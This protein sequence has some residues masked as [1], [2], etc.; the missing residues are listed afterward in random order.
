MVYDEQEEP[1]RFPRRVTAAPPVAVPASPAVAASA[2]RAEGRRRGQA[3]A[4][5]LAEMLLLT[6][7]IFLTVRALVVNFRVDGNSMQPTLD[8]GA[9]LLVN[10]AVYFHLDLN[11]LRNLLPGEDADHQDRVY[12]FHPPARGDIVVFHPPESSDTPFVKRVIALPGE[13]VAVRSGRVYVD[14][15]PIAEPYIAGPARYLYPREGRDLVVPDG[16]VFVLGDNRNNSRDS[17]AFG[18]VGLDS[19]IGKAVVSYWPPGDV[20][21]IPHQPYAQADDR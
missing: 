20:G 14:G 8:N 13:T 18:P 17:H 12:L 15:R 4:R 2:G 21:R 16:M 6:L 7:V 3:F 10:R 1:A 9:Y 5:E 19:I 11:R